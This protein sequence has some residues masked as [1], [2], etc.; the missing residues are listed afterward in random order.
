MCATDEFLALF[1]T[2]T[3]FISSSASSRLI[4]IPSYVHTYSDMFSQA[5][6]KCLSFILSVYFF[7]FCVMILWTG[8]CIT[9]NCV[10]RLALIFHWSWSFWTCVE[11]VIGVNSPFVANTSN[12]QCHLHLPVEIWLLLNSHLVLLCS[13]HI[14]H[15]NLFNKYNVFES[16]TNKLN[17]FML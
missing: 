15:L 10:F 6:H 12:I 14:L 16:F 3:L 17:I 4:K 5:C 9:C 13:N 2:F 1:D 8:N 11:D 7:I